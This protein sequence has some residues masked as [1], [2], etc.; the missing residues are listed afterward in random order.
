MKTKRLNYSKLDRLAF[1]RQTVR[2]YDENGRMKIEMAN[3]SKANVCPYFGK[4]IPGSKE[5]GLDPEKVYMLLRDPVELA[6]GA[7]TFNDIQ[8]MS[9]H[10]GVHASLPQKEYVA[11]TTGSN[12]VFDPP[13]L[14]NNLMIWDQAAIDGVESDEQRELSSSYSYVPDM[15]P[16]IYEGVPY[17]G[18]MTQ[19]VGNHVALVE[20]G[21]AGADVLVGDHLP[22][23]LTSM[24]L[25]KNTVAL[26]VALGACLRPLL[27][28]DG[29]IPQLRVLVPAGS[30]KKPATIAKDT[31]AL[32]KGKAEIDIEAL[33]KQL[34][35]ASDEA[36]MDDDAEDEEEDPEKPEGGAPKP[37]KDKA[38]DKA[39]DSD[40][41]DEEKKAREKKEA[42][43]EAEEEKK[44]KAEDKKAMDAAIATAVTNTRKQ[45]MADVQAMRVA[46]DAVRP[47]VGDLAA[48]DS[49][50]AVYRHAL[51]SV[52]I[53]TSKIKDVN[54][55]AAMV[56]MA[57]D[58]ASTAAAPKR[59]LAND[60]ANDDFKAMY[61]NAVAPGRA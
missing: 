5:L 19:I 38:K 15:T 58:S 9:V 7:S 36:D 30:K 48:M 52:G 16:G 22:M 51:D 21:R 25:T 20:K 53:D 18:R 59:V 32:F 33:T 24:K 55:L 56:N 31:A 54:A 3:I 2:S 44:D 12:C 10:I 26:R 47:L 6:K 11:G 8:L 29:A 49:A 43:D 60:A 17:D 34:Q 50:E 23:E 41:T 57:K 61:P 45:V 28:Q 37:G 27:A 46:E 13:Y 4:E 35:L 40:E 1:D 42:E 14:K 39:K